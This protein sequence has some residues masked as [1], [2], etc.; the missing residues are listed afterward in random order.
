M[1]SLEHQTK[2]KQEK[3]PNHWA[4]YTQVFIYTRGRKKKSGSGK[5]LNF[6]FKLKFVELW[7]FG[8][9]ELL[10][11]DESIYRLRIHTGCISIET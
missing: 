3:S 4:N 8:I 2:Q 1:S 5:T 7:D 6:E 10:D 9:L 11:L